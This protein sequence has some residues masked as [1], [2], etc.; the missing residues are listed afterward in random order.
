MLLSIIKRLRCGMEKYTSYEKIDKREVTAFRGLESDLIVH[1][2]SSSSMGIPLSIESF[3]ISKPNKNYY[4]RRKQSTYFILEYIV[5]GKGTLIN[6]GKHYPLRAGDTYLLEPGSSHEYFSDQRD[7][8]Q[9]YWVNFKSDLF[10]DILKAYSLSDV[11]VFQGVDLSENFQKL[12]A[13]EQI[14]TENQAIFKQASVILFEM[15]MRL[16][17]LTDKAVEQDTLAYKIR[18]YLDR[19][20]TAKISLKEIQDSL[21][22]SRS[23]LIR[24]FKKEYGVTP[25]DY[26]LEEKIKL[27]K[28]LLRNTDYS[29][30]SIA[31]R[32][33]FS[34]EHYFSGFFKKKVGLTPS[35]YRKEKKEKTSS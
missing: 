23:K 10:F 35:E 11:T 32:L 8:M 7:P 17:E 9:K 21:F 12:F 4:I 5:S 16:A 24:A 19:A 28:Q 13:L 29:V 1:I 30:R 22:I 15:F 6:N 33:D 26:L 25:Y 31:E 20:L 2:S 34:D 14:S 18:S 3:G 27:A